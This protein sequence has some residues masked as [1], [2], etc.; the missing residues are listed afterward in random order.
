M[1]VRVRMYNTG[2]G[3]CFLLTFSVADRPRKVLIDCGKHTL[4]STG[5][6][7]SRVVDQLL[8]D[9]TEPAGAKV[10]VVI[11]THRH[12]DHV[13]GFSDQRWQNVSVG[14]VWMPW[15]EDP[16][17][18]IARGICE[19]Q[20]QRALRLE[21]GL[22][23]MTA[24]PEREY[25]LGYAG[26]NLTNSAAMNLLHE[27]FQGNPRRRFL[28]E[29]D[30]TRN[31]LRT[32]V[33]PGVDIYVLGPPR[34]TNVM[35]QMDP[36]V[37]ESFFRAW[38]FDTQKEGADLP[39]P[40][41][42]KWFL[43]RKQYEKRTRRSL[44]E[45]LPITSEGR[46]GEVLVSPTLELLT[47]LEEAVNATSLVLLFRVGS[48]W[49]LFPGDAQWGTWNAI[50]NHPQH[51]KLLENLSFYKVGHHGSHNATPISFV[52][53]YVSDRVLAMI[54]YG[55]VDR[56]PTIP[57]AGLLTKF[58]DKKVKFARSD[59]SAVPAP[60]K[61]TLVD[62]DVLFIDAEVQD[63]GRQPAPLI[64]GSHLPSAAGAMLRSR[65][66]RRTSISSSK[67]SRR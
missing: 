30:E 52:E 34:D 15:T 51:A 16:N 5:P 12:R 43:N 62:E 10:D 3:D 21:L 32:D 59:V 55:K 61:V 28:P 48:A 37:N 8:A 45:D 36:P 60:F 24:D 23:A 53:R 31:P 49:L 19:R 2:F 67:T 11:A 22:N 1:S 4:S 20:S 65:P 33:L 27:G 42:A 26:N 9:I 47:R 56:W 13:Q 6:K 14:E 38:D 18:P 29:A 46:I 7:L 63:S 44:A 58:N 25:L 40:F 50:L 57:R 41:S 54:P 39:S 66:G 17:D 64:A 35:R